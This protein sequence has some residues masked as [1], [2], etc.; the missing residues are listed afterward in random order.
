MDCDLQSLV[1]HALYSPVFIKKRLLVNAIGLILMPQQR[2]IKALNSLKHFVENC[3]Y[4]DIKWE[5]PRVHI[6]LHVGLTRTMTGYSTRSETE[7]P[8]DLSITD[9]PLPFH[10]LPGSTSRRVLAPSIMVSSENADVRTGKSGTPDSFARCCRPAA[11]K[12]PSGHLGT[13]CAASLP[14]SSLCH[15]MSRSPSEKE[16]SRTLTVYTPFDASSPGGLH[17]RYPSVCVSCLVK[18]I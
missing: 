15:K 9:N 16:N 4:D 6:S 12:E 11:T 14:I 17:I 5:S 3:L 18:G 7:D 10:T 8:A 2:V 1:C 13:V